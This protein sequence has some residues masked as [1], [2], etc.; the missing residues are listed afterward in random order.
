M[1]FAGLNRKRLCMSLANSPDRLAHSFCARVPPPNIR[2]PESGNGD[3]VR[4]SEETDGT[5]VGMD[6]AVLPYAF[7]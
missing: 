2:A 7:R 3:G 4:L 5:L 1:E 6:S